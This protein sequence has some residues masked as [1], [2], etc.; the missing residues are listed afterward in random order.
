MRQME[1]G[2]R[3]A[4]RDELCHEVYENGEKK[5]RMIW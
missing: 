3:I 4:N 1:G 5:L 2:V